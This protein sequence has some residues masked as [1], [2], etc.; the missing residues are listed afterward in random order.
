MI[1]HEARAGKHINCPI[2]G[3]GAVY[4]YGCI[5][6]GLRN[7]GHRSVSWREDKFVDRVTFT[8]YLDYPVQYDQDSSQRV[9]YR[10]S[11]DGF[12]SSIWGNLRYCEK[13]DEN[14]YMACDGGTSYIKSGKSM[15]FAWDNNINRTVSVWVDTDR[16]KSSDQDKYDMYIS[17]GYINHWTLAEPAPANAKSSVSPGV[18]CREGEANGMDCILAYVD[19]EL[20]DG[21]IKVS[22][23]VG[24]SLGSHYTAW[25]DQNIAQPAGKTSHRIAAWYHDDAFWIAYK[26]IASGEYHRVEKYW[27][28]FDLWASSSHDQFYGIQGPA[29]IGYWSGNNR[30]FFQQP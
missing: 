2:W 8:R 6:G 11:E 30:L 20:G 28:D 5:A 15:S 4:S 22:R 1:N 21:T 16:T 19:A 12:D 14:G 25:G 23:F 18:A 26:D 10:R 9:A 17:Y 29:A 27:P 3:W 24:V 13:M 7:H